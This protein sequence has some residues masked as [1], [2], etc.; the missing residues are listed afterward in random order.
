MICSP[1]PFIL[2]HIYKCKATSTR[3]VISPVKTTRR[4][5]RLCCYCTREIVRPAVAIAHDCTSQYE[6]GLLFFSP[7][8]ESSRPPPTRCDVRV[9][10]ARRLPSTSGPGEGLPTRAQRRR[11]PPIADERGRVVVAVVGPQRGGFGDG[12]R[13]PE[14]EQGP[15]THIRSGARALCQCV[16]VRCVFTCVCVRESSW[17]PRARA[18]ACVYIHLP[19]KRSPRRC[20]RAFLRGR[21][22]RLCWLVGRERGRVTREERR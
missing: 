4:S 9:S 13:A 1:R 11:R 14:R 21:H 12:V 8:P 10:E 17:A 3:A 5:P 2:C 16:C 7:T 18:R 20:F 15:V 19:R 22:A 6:V